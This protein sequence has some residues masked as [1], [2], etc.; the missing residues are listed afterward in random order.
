MLAAV[1]IAVRSHSIGDDWVDVFDHGW[2]PSSFEEYKGQ[3]TADEAVADAHAGEVAGLMRLYGSYDDVD[4]AVQYACMSRP[5]DLDSCKPVK[6]TRAERGKTLSLLSW[7][8]SRQSD[9]SLLLEPNSQSASKRLEAHSH[10]DAVGLGPMAYSD[11]LLMAWP[12]WKQ[13]QA[14]GSEATVVTATDS[15]VSVPSCSKKKDGKAWPRVHS[16][17]ASE[18]THWVMETGKS[19]SP[20]V[21]VDVDRDDS[22][23]RYCEQVRAGLLP[24]CSFMIANHLNGHA[25]FYW[26]V[27][28][29]SK[30]NAGAVALRDG[31]VSSIRALLGGDKMFVGYRCQNPYS[32]RLMARK[33]DVYVPGGDRGFRL[34]SMRALSAFM[35]TAGSWRPFAAVGGADGG[36]E[37]TTVLDLIRGGRLTAS[38]QGDGSNRALDPSGVSSIPVGERQN[39][40]FRMAT[41]LQWHEGSLERLDSLN[42]SLCESPLGDDEVRRIRKNVTAYYE[43]HHKDVAS[44]DGSRG[45]SPVAVELGRRGGSAGTGLQCASRNAVL[46]SRREAMIRQGAERSR[47]AWRRVVIGGE[48]RSSVARS[49]SVTR[50]AVSGMLSRLQSR[51]QD[52]VVRKAAR[53]LGWP[54]ADVEAVAGADWAVVAVVR[55]VAVSVASGEATGDAEKA[56]KALRDAAVGVAWLLARCSRRV[57][58]DKLARRLAAA[59]KWGIDAVGVAGSDDAGSAVHASRAASSPAERRLRLVARMVDYSRLRAEVDSTRQATASSASRLREAEGLLSTMVDDDEIPSISRGSLESTASLLSRVARLAVVD[60]AGL[61]SRCSGGEDAVVSAAVGQV[62]SVLVDSWVTSSRETPSQSSPVAASA[63]ATTGEPLTASGGSGSGDRG[64]SRVGMSVSSETLGH[65]ASSGIDLYLVKLLFPDYDPSRV[66]VEAD[67]F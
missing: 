63:G 8:A 66:A 60:D 17:S 57:D 34:W 18:Y 45:K 46:S 55:T 22:V 14:V 47:E 52:H 53:V 48:S 33:H 21:V 51:A 12:D 6:M 20:F 43:K 23:A 42:E 4:E 35:Q 15:R 10:M 37:P 19:T 9:G 36:D 31:V 64:P 65:E 26:V 40:L 50:Q 54:V 28:A 56:K 16:R 24:E 7:S 25:Q 67:E 27:P 39:T 44:G 61:P 2:L 13:L 30:A 49:M 38:K 58:A 29:A 41:W 59:S 11:L 5:I 62:P 32:V 3:L 1:G